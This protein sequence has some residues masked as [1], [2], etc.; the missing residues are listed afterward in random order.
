VVCPLSSKIRA[1]FCGLRGSSAA[2][3]WIVSGCRRVSRLSRLSCLSVEAWLK[4]ARAMTAWRHNGRKQDAGR[5]GSAAPAQSGVPGPG[6]G[7]GGGVSAAGIAQAKS[8]QLYFGIDLGTT[9][10]LTRSV[11]VPPPT[12][13]AAPRRHVYDFEGRA[14]TISTARPTL[15]GRSVD[16]A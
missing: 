14:A 16:G 6:Q 1:R 10:A 4:L 13:V 9:S 15:R 3:W 11:Y 5:G 12:N 8:N 7:A 2:R